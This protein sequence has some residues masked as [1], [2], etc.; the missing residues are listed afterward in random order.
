L[1]VLLLFGGTARAEEKEPSAVVAIGP[2]GELGFPGGRFSIGPSASVE[3]SVIENWLEI[4]I[5]GGTLF[6]RGQKEWEADVL[7][8]KPFTLSDTVE[9]GW[10]WTLMELRHRRDRE[11]R[12]HPSIARCCLGRTSK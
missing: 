11:D 1:A 2:E 5:G 7:F 9:H 10:R 12:R 3:F 4:E 6:G 8:K